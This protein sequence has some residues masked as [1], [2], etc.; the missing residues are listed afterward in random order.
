[1]RQRQIESVI[2][3][4]AN[5]IGYP[6]EERMLTPPFLPLQQQQ[7]LSLQSL[8]VFLSR[9]HGSAG[10]IRY[11]YIHHSSSFQRRPS[12]HRPTSSRGQPLL[13]VIK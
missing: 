5:E 6:S 11:L 2:K 9:Q 3:R 13:K 4:A 1:M 7:P 8:I 10:T 12:C